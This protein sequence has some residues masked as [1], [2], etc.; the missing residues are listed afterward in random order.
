MQRTRRVVVG[1]LAGAGVAGVAGCL[2]AGGIE[3]P[4]AGPEDDETDD[5]DDDEQPEVPNAELAD[6]TRAVV[7][8]TL[9]FAEEYYDATRA[10][11][12]AIDD[13][14]SEIDSVRETVR[15]DDR[16]DEEMADDLETVGREAADRAA[17]ALEPH[18]SPRAGIER[19]VERHVSELRTFI[20]RDDVDRVIEELDRMESA[21]RRIGTRSY[22]N[23]AF[24]RSPIHNRLLEDRLVPPAVSDDHEESIE[25]TLVEI[26]VGDEFVTAAYRPYDEDE[27]DDD[28]IPRILGLPI[29]SNQRLDRDYRIELRARLG[30]VK[31]TDRR[32]DEL[33]YIFSERPEAG[34]DEEV[35]I[36]DLGGPAVYVQRYPDAET[37][38]ARLETALDA[39]R[40]EGRESIDPDEDGTEW[41]RYFHDEVDEEYDAGGGEGVQYGYLV[42]A[43]EFLLAAAFSGE[44]WEERPS[45]QGTL[46]NGWV[47][48]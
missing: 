43:G 19:R 37:A 2:G 41:H 29:G 15:T 48:V 44:A 31:R 21:M 27:L 3:Y 39:G 35:W 9:W 4:D 36:H 13:V 28:E 42:Q 22:V 16:V 33:F 23:D 1:S 18:F 25:E 12:D 14:V 47:V 10:Y 45:W 34:N 38:G 7:D 46:A 24:S 40:T 17:E 8:D 20:P 26:A 11:L 5:D 32:T 30:P 6:A